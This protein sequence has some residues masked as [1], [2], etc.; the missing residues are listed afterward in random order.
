MAP[1]TE[2]ALTK[3]STDGIHPL[4]RTAFFLPQ[5]INL[6]STTSGHGVC[7][8]ILPRPAVQ[9]RYDIIFLQPN[10]LNDSI[11]R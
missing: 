2:D 6:S 1:T 9:P 5:S 3:V 8:V 4:H 10:D 7:P 11:Q